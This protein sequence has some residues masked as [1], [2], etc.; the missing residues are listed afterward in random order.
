MVLPREVLDARKAR[1]RKRH[2]I[3]WLSIGGALVLLVVFFCLYQFT[4]L[5]FGVPATAH[6]E[7]QSSSEWTCFRR[8]L[9]HTGN[10]GD[11]TAQPEGTLKWTFATGA[12]VRSSP[13]V[14]DGTVYFGSEDHFIYA[15]DAAT[16]NLKWKYETGS[17]VAS[18]P[19]VSGGVLY[20][21]SND[22][23]LYALNAATGEL[24]WSFSSV[25]SIRSSPC[26]ADGII[27]FGSDD[28]RMYAVNAAT[29]KLVWKTRVNSMVNTSPLVSEGIVVIPAPEGMCY[30][31][32]A[33]SGRVRLKYITT[34]YIRS[35]AA[36][37]D[38]VIYFTDTDGYFTALDIGSKNWLWEHKV[39]MYWNVLHAYGLAPNSPRPSGF[40]WGVLLNHGIVSSSSPAL[41]G[42]HAY[43]G[44]VNDVVS[45]DLETHAVQ[46]TFN[47][48]DLVVSSPA[49]ATTALYVGGQ[50]GHLYALDKADG[51]LLW[52]H[53][54]GSPVRSSPALDNGMLFIGCDD[55]VLYA[56]K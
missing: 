23:K 52:D 2:R 51:S 50:D 19:I 43:L 3:I 8:D 53:D 30:T 28:F 46:W 11:S 20:C 9:E 31:F 47:T 6:S 38:G 39:R 26:I 56:F 12:P 33:K 5:F 37:Q 17:F 32:N 45:V 24:I 25:Y 54:L 15:L 41:S 14:V 48:S 36:V 10:T 21:G 44:V 4:D 35:S 34:T 42:G 7:P 55:G 18:S 16:G 1:A 49:L 29:G 22:A 13:A 27:Y 40:L